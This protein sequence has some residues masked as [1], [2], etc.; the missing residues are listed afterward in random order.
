MD[1][2][3]CTS[4]LAVALETLSNSSELSIINLPESAK[5][6]LQDTLNVILHAAT[7]S[8]NSPESRCL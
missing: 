7:S 2:S 4:L 6:S 1:F 3:K 5:Y 8:T